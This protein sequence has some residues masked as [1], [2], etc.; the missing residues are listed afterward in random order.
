VDGQ[1]VAICRLKRVASDL[2]ANLRAP[3]GHSTEKNGKRIACIG[4]GPSAL[5]VAND[6]LPSL[7]VVMFEQFAKP[8]GSCAP[9]SRV[10]SADH[11]LED[12]TQV[13][14]DMGVEVR[15]NTPITS[16]RS[17]LGEGSTRSSWGRCTAR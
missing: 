7:R 6:L 1:P 14:L 5:T 9:T 11:V 17:L 10:P 12:E 4:S 2:K 15:Y 3:S 16:L 8:G 13:I